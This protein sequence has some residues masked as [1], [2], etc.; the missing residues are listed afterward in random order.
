MVDHESAHLLGG[1][2]AADVA[3]QR[4]EVG[5]EARV[6]G[7]EFCL[8]FWPQRDQLIADAVSHAHHQWWR[9]PDV[10]IGCAASTRRCTGREI[11]RTHGQAVT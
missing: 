6:V 5:N 3:I 11:D 2:T 4:L 1:Q 9:K 7:F 10:R 8:C